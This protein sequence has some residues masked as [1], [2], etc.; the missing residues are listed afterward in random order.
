[1]GMPT[2][3]F[4]VTKKFANYE[5]ISEGNYLDGKRQGEWVHSF[6]NGLKMV[7]HYDN[8]IAAPEI[9]FS[10]LG[11]TG[12]IAKTPVSIPLNP[13]QVLVVNPDGEYLVLN[14]EG[15]DLK[16]VGTK[17]HVN[18]YTYTGEFLGVNNPVPFYAPEGIGSMTFSYGVY[19]GPFKSG[20]PDIPDHYT[21]S[22][23]ADKADFFK[24]KK[25]L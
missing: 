17:Y 16:R 12:K 5:T 10:V 3:F 2:G 13:S 14:V 15:G 23:K 25:I 18:G 6:V 19:S 11:V 4:K 9:T 24:A 21:R 22:I 20:K 7:A 8:G 1:K